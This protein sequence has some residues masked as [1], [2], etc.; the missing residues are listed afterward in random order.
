VL[1]ALLSGLT[2][3]ALSATTLCAPGDGTAADAGSLRQLCHHDSERPASGHSVL[4]QL[5]H[6]GAGVARSRSDRDLTAELPQ[7]YRLAVWLV[8]RRV[9]AFVTTRLS[10]PVAAPSSPRAPPSTLPS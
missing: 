1:T 2:A 9:R 4:T 7:Q 10:S 6:R 5:P 3:L 8:G